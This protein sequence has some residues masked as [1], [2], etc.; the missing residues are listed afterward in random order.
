[1]P[2]IFGLMVS[3]AIDEVIICQ[4]SVFVVFRES[5]PASLL[6]C[7]PRSSRIRHRLYYG[8]FIVFIYSQTVMRI[9]D[10]DAEQVG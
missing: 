6:C 4:S 7:H 10:V 3:I 9:K 8:G 1:M 2:C 5:T